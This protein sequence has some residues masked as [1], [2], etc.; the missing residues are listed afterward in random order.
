MNASL[1]MLILIYSYIMAEVNP[2]T[3]VLENFDSV[4][5][6]TN[7]GKL[8]TRLPRLQDANQ[9]QGKDR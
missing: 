1:Y 8:L 3:N 6:A 4:A 2:D 7:S 5:I 9:K